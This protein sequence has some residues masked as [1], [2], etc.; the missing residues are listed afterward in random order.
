MMLAYRLVKLIERHSEGLAEGLHEK[1]TTSDKTLDYVN[2]PAEELTRVV[3]EMY[4]NL[5]EWLL[6]KTEADIESRY[7]A[8]GA[9][10]A[11]QNV[12]L[13]QVVWTIML[14]KENMLEYLGKE[15]VME[16]PAEVFGELEILQLLEQ[17]FDRAVYYAALGYE[18]SRAAQ[19]ASHERG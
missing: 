4:R 17:F 9:R 12:P 6:G 3:R 18:R 1:I 10:R 14:V 7:T 19:V 13:S 16:R 15:D 8:I 5:G 11:E 2:V